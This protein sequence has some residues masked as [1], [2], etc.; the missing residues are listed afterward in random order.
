MSQKESERLSSEIIKFVD[1][2]KNLSP[3]G[4]ITHKFFGGADT[5]NLLRLNTFYAALYGLIMVEDPDPDYFGVSD[6]DSQKAIIK[7]TIEQLPDDMLPLFQY[8]MERIMELLN[9][10]KYQTARRLI[11]EWGQPVVDLLSDG[12]EPPDYIKKILDELPEVEI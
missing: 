5:E 1:N 9:E 7:K 2:L 10:K 6:R 12:R 3:L 4:N 8:Q 11:Y